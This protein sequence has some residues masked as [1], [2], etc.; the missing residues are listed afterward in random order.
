MLTSVNFDG[1]MAGCDIELINNFQNY[2]NVPLIYRGGLSSLENIKEVFDTK[3][4]AITSSS[5][6]IM[7]KKEEGLFCTILLR[8]IKKKYAKM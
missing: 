3:V 8:R 5:F 4:N 2:I 1:L 6:F 7:K